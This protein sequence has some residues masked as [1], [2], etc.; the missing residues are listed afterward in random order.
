MDYSA[1][2]IFEVNQLIGERIREFESRKLNYGATGPL[3]PR[4]MLYVLDMLLAM[5][6]KNGQPK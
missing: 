5:E 3:H 2:P 4:T 6:A 1:I